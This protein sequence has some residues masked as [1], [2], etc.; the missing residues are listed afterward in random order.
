MN[1]LALLPGLP[2]AATAINSAVRG[3]GQTVNSFAAAL[4]AATGASNESP[5]ADESTPG[6]S[7]VELTESYL[8]QPIRRSDLKALARQMLELVQNELQRQASAAG[9]EEI[10]NVQLR[11]QPADGQI[12]V[13]GDPASR[14]AIEQILGQDPTLADLVRQAVAA[15]E[16]VRADE[17]T[18]RF[19]LDEFGAI[20]RFV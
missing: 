9:I 15:Q 2:L 1:P 13:T 8:G 14:A 16:S 20:A 18:I 5:S 11:I 3:V 6:A 10:E 12:V 17:S 19:S 7:L 4:E